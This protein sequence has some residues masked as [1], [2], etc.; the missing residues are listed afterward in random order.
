MYGVI[1]KMLEKW[2]LMGIIILQI[3]TPLYYYTFYN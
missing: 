3:A 1:W 2:D